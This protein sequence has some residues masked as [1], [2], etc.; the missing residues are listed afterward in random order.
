MA[1]QVKRDL[2]CPACGLTQHWDGPI[3]DKWVQKIKCQ[4]GQLITV[5]TDEEI[6]TG[7]IKE[8]E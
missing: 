5:Q 3:S 1:V 8:D 7:E 6:K 4:C 2:V